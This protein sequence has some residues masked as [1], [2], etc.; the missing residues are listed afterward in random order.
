MRLYT[1]VADKHSSNAPPAYL[2]V[3]TVLTSNVLSEAATN[4][5]HALINAGVAKLQNLLTPDPNSDLETLLSV[6]IPASQGINRVKALVEQAKTMDGELIDNNAWWVDLF[7]AFGQKDTAV[8]KEIRDAVA[9][10][11]IGQ[12]AG[13]QPSGS[14]SGSRSQTRQSGAGF[15]IQAA[16][17]QVQADRAKLKEQLAQNAKDRAASA[18]QI[19]KL[20]AKIAEM[21]RGGMAEELY[22]EVAIALLNEESVRSNLRF[23]AGSTRRLGSN[24]T[25][26]IIYQ[27]WLDEFVKSRKPVKEGFRDFIDNARTFL[28]NPNHAAA[29]MDDSTRKNRNQRAAKLAVQLLFGKLK[30]ELAQRLKLANL[31]LKDMRDTLILWKQLQAKYQDGA[32]DQQFIA[33]VKETFEKLKR[34]I[35]AVNP[36]MAKHIMAMGL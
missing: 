24:S 13:A 6:L 32:R 29:S 26:P 19:A 11:F 23:L 18:E 20:K 8:Q 3:E 9:K 17:A 34:I 2:F 31:T 1:I 10:E 27:N 33:K 15:D 22:K 7:N 30:T 25:T 5:L 14:R 21:E 36:E 16:I 35:M 12:Q 4:R 28:G